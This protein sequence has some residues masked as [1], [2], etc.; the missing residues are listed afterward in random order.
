MTEYDN[1]LSGVLFVNDK[2]GNDARPDF[3]GKVQIEGV[4]Y[5]LAA[6]KKTGN[7]SGKTFLSLKAS[8]PQQ[9]T[10]GVAAG[11]SDE[12]ADFEF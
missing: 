1:E 7:N 3:T 10:A 4:E 6:W 9:E 12:A 5:R 2:E 11:G 8:L